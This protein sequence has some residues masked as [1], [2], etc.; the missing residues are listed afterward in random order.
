MNPRGFIWAGLFVQDMDA[1]IT[2]YSEILGLPLLRRGDE[3]AH[4][5]AGN[6]ALFELFIG[7]VTSIRPK[8]P[9]QQSLMVSFQ[10][11]DL[12]QTIEDLKQK[13]VHFIGQIG[14]YQSTRWA[15]FYDL[16]GNRLEIKEIASP[17]T[18]ERPITVQN[19]GSSARWRFAV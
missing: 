10:V 12:D 17:T 6:G 3:W 7:G 8:M 4:F 15:H 16:E 1:A 2:F 18:L 9:D 13:G 14:Q 5:D 19:T 11:D